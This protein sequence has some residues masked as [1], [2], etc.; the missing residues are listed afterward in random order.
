MP[1]PESLKTAYDNADI[2]GAGIQPPPLN[3]V[4]MVG[5]YFG[6]D[7]ELSFND[8]AM[9]AYTTGILPRLGLP[10]SQSLKSAGRRGVRHDAP[11]DFDLINIDPIY[12]GR[13]F[14]KEDN[15]KCDVLMFCNI[16]WAQSQDA[17]AVSDWT[18]QGMTDRQ[19]IMYEASMRVSDLNRREDLWNEKTRATGAKVVVI[20]GQDDFPPKKLAGDDFAVLLTHAHQIGILIKKDYL[21][22]MEPTIKA[23]KGL[24]APVVETLRQKPDQVFFRGYDGSRELI[25]RPSSF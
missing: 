8:T 12:G 22:S 17:D 4:V 20:A 11:G 15:V 3:R 5:A 2:A 24:L 13:D 7:K 23:Q 19:K 1:D 9:L 10:V 16:A 6:L 18:M 25:F 14:L 21:L